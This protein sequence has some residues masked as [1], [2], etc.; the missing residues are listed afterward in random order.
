[1]SKYRRFSDAEVLAAC[2]RRLE[3]D[4]YVQWSSIGRELGVTGSAVMRRLQKLVV[5]GTLSIEEFNQYAQ[6]KPDIIKDS[7]RAERRKRRH[8]ISFTPENDAWLR[9]ESER[10]DLPIFKLVNGLVNQKRLST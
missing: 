3:S 4:G 2:A 7:Q 5:Q 9:S 10:T 6:L 1:L 8:F